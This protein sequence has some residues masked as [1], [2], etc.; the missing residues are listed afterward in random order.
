MES[1]IQNK[2]QSRNYVVSKIETVIW[3]LVR[4]FWFITDLNLFLRCPGNFR[5]SLDDRKA[6]R[7]C[8]CHGHGDS[9]DPVTGEKCNCQNNTES[10]PTCQ[11]SGS[12]NSNQ[13]C[14]MV[15]CSKC[16]DTYL[17]TPTAGHQCYR[18][19]TVD[20]KFCFDAKQLG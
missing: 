4:L 9:C 15:Q 14:W 17:G 12:K 1:K 20:T 3:V 18:Q 13:Q 8:E 19:M 16:R 2:L 6:C 5:G 7:P 11:S 10:D